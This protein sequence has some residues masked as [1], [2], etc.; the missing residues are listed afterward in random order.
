MALMC[1][2][3]MTLLGYQ[4]Y[5]INAL[6]YL[7][8]S[9]SGS[10]LN[11]STSGLHRREGLSFFGRFGIGGLQNNSDLDYER[12]YASH[13]VFGLGLEYGFRNGFALRAEIQGFDEDARYVSAS[14]LK[15]F[16]KVRTVAPV[17]VAPEPVEPAPVVAPIEAPTLFKP[18]VAPYIYFAFDESTLSEDAKARLVTYVEAIQDTEL[19]IYVEGHTDWIGGESYNDSLSLR[20]ARAVR[21]HLVT[22]GIDAE[23]IQAVG[24]GES[25]PLS[26]NDN[27]EGRA[28]N[29]R[30][31][32]RLK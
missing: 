10:L 29:R 19:D 17:V 9:R 6:A 26:S 24:L 22:L 21:D 25:F 1:S 13:A 15:R 4:V 18:V 7:F 20:R 16:G 8:N 3:V 23:R 5:G 30:A 32:M 27:A 2:W 28:E 11:T 12:D 14:V 31:E